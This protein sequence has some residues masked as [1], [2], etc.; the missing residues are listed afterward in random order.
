M[1]EIRRHADA[2]YPWAG[3]RVRIETESRTGEGQ[4]PG[5]IKEYEEREVT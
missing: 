3:Q 1:S 2:L 5:Y 4:R